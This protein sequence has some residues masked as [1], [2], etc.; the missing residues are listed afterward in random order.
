MRALVL[1][2]A[3]AVVCLAGCRAQTAP[4]T[5]QK[6]QKP[7]PIDKEQ[8]AQLAAS[9]ANDECEV[10]FGDR[11]FKAE[12]FEAVYRDGRWHWGEFDPAGVHGYSA[13]VSFDRYGELWM[14]EVFYSVDTADTRVTIEPDRAP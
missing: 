11:P 2:L 13:E 10:K 4:N 3:A 12:H 9:L 8:A 5:S 7:A 1:I 14:M 6:T